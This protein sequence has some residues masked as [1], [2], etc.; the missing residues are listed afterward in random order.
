MQE[1]KIKVLNFGSLNIDD[2][3][4]VDHFVK[5]GETLLATDQQRFLGGKGFNQSV[6]LALAGVEVHHAGKVG[7]DGKEV[8]EQCREYGIHADGI[9]ISSKPTGHAIIQIDSKGQNTIILSG[10]ANQDIGKAHID[11]VLSHFSAGDYLLIQ[12]E[13]SDLSYLIS[14]AKEKGL[15]IVF[16]PAPMNSHVFSY[17][18]DLIDIFILNEIEAADLSGQQ[19][20]E[21]ALT[22]LKTRYADAEI[23]ITQ[24]SKGVLYLNAEG[25]L[26]TVLALPVKVVDTTAA[27]DT[28]VG[29][30]LSAL[31][32][33]LTLADAI[34]LANR[35]ASITVQTLG[36]SNSIPRTKQV[37]HRSL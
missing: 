20:T 6:A 33:G 10:G 24:G 37:N 1:K 14:T 31:V 11:E 12:N 27:G 13:I 28:F 4:Q 3:Y 29:Y 16:N 32:Q 21:A 23:I 26:A 17:P 30:F 9:A 8:L 7:A 15:I 36:A 35:A 34:D 18:L 25:E 5:P 2:V 19:E 22:F